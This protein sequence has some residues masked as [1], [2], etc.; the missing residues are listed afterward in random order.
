MCTVTV[1][2]NENQI[3]KAN[4]SLTSKDAITRWVQRLVD[5]CIADLTDDDKNEK[6]EP[7][8]LEELN[9]RIEKAER[10]I[11]E[12]KFISHEELFARFRQQTPEMI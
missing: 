6:L 2:I 9:A 4:P 8:T 3:R 10:E 12:G 11:A 7:Y 5:N 1:N